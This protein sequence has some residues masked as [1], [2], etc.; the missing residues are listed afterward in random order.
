MFFT[1]LLVVF[2]LSCKC[3]LDNVDRGP[4]YAVQINF[5]V[6]FLLVYFETQFLILMKFT[7]SILKEFY[8]LSLGSILS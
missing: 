1:G 5:I 4:M 6:T 3:S 2:L 8:S 7:S